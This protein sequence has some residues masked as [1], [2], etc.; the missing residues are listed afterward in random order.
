MTDQNLRLANRRAH[1]GGFFIGAGVLCTVAL[2]LAGC[3]GLSKKQDSVATV[4]QTSQVE[5]AQA[6]FA[7]SERARK[8]AVQKL[9]IAVAANK[10][11]KKQLAGAKN[12]A[13]K[14]RDEFQAADK[15]I[16]DL[17]AQLSKANA[18]PGETETMRSAVQQSEQLV[19]SLKAR[20]D[21]AGDERDVLKAQLDEAQKGSAQVIEKMLVAAS[22]E[23]K[24]SKQR[25]EQLGGQIKA[26]ESEKSELKQRLEKA[27][28]AL[29][30]RTQVE[31]A[32]AKQAEAL[33]D[34]LATAKRQ[35]SD[36]Q[37]AAK[38]ARI[39]LATANA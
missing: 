35:M 4:G 34:Q 38:T 8:A 21:K 2:T 17:E 15:D 28:S 33:R 1:R 39:E 36:A 5:T 32:A 27:D 7:K 16:A 31:Q 37:A 24:E 26:V 22:Q 18:Q 30:E 23:A 19:E 11:L 25:I 10:T 9:A 3:S 12:T 29:K 6:R 20:L 14:F 13:R